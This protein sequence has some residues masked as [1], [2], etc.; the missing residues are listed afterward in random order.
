[1]SDPVPNRSPEELRPEAPTREPVPGSRTPPAGSAGTATRAAEP[2]NAATD[3]S[4]AAERRLRAALDTV[5]D[6]Y[7]IYRPQFDDAGRYADSRIVYTNLAWRILFLGYDARDVESRSVY[8]VV[9]SLRGRTQL[10]ARIAETGEPFRGVVDIETPRGTRWAELSMSLVG[11]EIVAFTRD[12]TTQRETEAAL[13][14]SREMLR[15]A[16]DGVIEGYAI[17]RSHLDAGGHYSDGTVVYANGTWKSQF[18]P[19]DPEVEGRS[20]Y[21]FPGA[22]G[23]FDVHARVVETGEPFR[24]LVELRTSDGVRTLDLQMVKFGPYFVGSSRDITDQLRAEAALRDSERRHREVVDGI[25]AVV[26]DE[27]TAGGGFFMS[28]NAERVLGYSNERFDDLSFWME[29]LHPE[30]RERRVGV[31]TGP[32]DADIEYRFDVGNGEY[33]WLR[34]RI[35]MIKDR[36]GNVVRRYGVTIDVNERREL[37]DQLRRS[38]RFSSVGQLAA[39]VSHDFDNVLYGVRMFAEHL[40]ESHPSPDDP[41]HIDADHI[42]QAVRSASELTHSLLAFARAQPTT[43]GRLVPDEVIQGLGPMLATVVGGQVVTDLRLHA[44]AEVV[45]GDASRVEQA[46]LNLAVNARDAMP[47]GGRLT[48]ETRV[49]VLDDED[50]ID[51]DVEPGRGVV[52]SFADTGVGMDEETRS[53]AFIPYFT[54]KEVGQGTGLGLATVFGT[55]KAANGGIAIRSTLGKGTTIQIFLPTAPSSYVP[56]VSPAA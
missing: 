33:R 56:G 35:H 22:R 26:W 53:K 31:M 24:G 20:L 14:E 50:A 45:K 44:G 15:Q 19:D 4:A 42:L 18:S 25:D 49:A 39:N 5:L 36:F 46:L 38:E 51:M 29:H 11:S 52:I 55:V 37:E 6:A 54:T 12:I 34:D 41:D 23:R 1:M 2:G 13:V 43:H 9:P 21:S 48:I 17:Y 27:D 8:E 32:D 40:L 47:S 28:R 10:H 30:D 16:M 7:A 3:A